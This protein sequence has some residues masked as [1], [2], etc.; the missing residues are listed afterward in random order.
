MPERN[1]AMAPSK[2]LRAALCAFLS[3]SFVFSL[4]ACRETG[5]E[6]SN[7]SHAQSHEELKDELQVQRQEDQKE[8]FAL[9][10]YKTPSCGCCGA[11]VEHIEAGGFRTLVQEKDDLSVIKQRFKV[12]PSIQSC[13]TAV[14]QEGFVFEGHV[15]QKFIRKF[16]SA[17]PENAYG[18]SVP[19]MPVGSPG[20]EYED[21]FLPYKILQL[22]QDGSIE[23]YA[24]VKTMAQQY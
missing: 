18:L 9:T 20:M 21:K 2:A 5:D 1:I 4:A 24:D 7:K 10:V 22:N 3:V 8:A 12:D 15:P 17:P 19:A 14:S 23:V 11:W 6:K 16:L 13:H